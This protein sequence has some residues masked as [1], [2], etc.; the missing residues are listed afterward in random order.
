MAAVSTK[1]FP[2]NPTTR[3]VT[4]D[5]RLTGEGFQM[6]MAV[7]QLVEAITIEDGE[8]TEAMIADASIT[9]A[10]IEDAAI[11]SAKIGNAAITNAKIGNLEV[12]RIKLADGAVTD[13]YFTGTSTGRNISRSSSWT[14]LRSFVVT[15]TDFGVMLAAHVYMTTLTS[16]H[17]TEVGLAVV[18]DGSD[19]LL[20]TSR[21]TP[22]DFVN[23][24]HFLLSANCVPGPVGSY[25]FKLMI[26]QDS[27]GGAAERSD[28]ESLTA[29]VA[30]K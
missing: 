24:F 20:A 27:S 14:T 30:Q 17:W 8:I 7:S 10:K 25:T 23:T 16:E 21:F 2:L 22:E 12:E 15:V 29:L 4:A 6:M 26:R 19:V 5:G 9:T 1:R 11:T 13:T 3:W 28:F 18:I